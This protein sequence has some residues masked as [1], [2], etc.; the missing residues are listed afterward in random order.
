MTWDVTVTDTFATSNIRSSSLS[1]GSAAEAAATKKELKYSDLMTKYSFVPIAFETLGTINEKGSEFIDE[2][3]KRS[4]ALSGDNR[5]RT[6]LWQRLSVAL[7]R[8]NSICFRGT[9][10]DFASLNN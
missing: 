4:H 3:G 10:G 8:Y 6:F 2:I 5:E 7:Q 9:F 1:A